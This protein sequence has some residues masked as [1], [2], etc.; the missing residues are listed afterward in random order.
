MTTV[1]R[2]AHQLRDIACI[3]WRPT[4]FTFF[5]CDKHH[6]PRQFGRKEFISDCNAQVT[7][8]RWEK[9]GQELKQ[10]PYKKTTYWPVPQDL[11]SLLCYTTWDYLQGLVL[12][13]VRWILTH[14]SSVEKMPHR[15]VYRPFWR[16]HLLGW[17]SLSSNG[18]PSIKGNMQGFLFGI[19][20]TGKISFHHCLEHFPNV[21]SPVLWSSLLG[22]QLIVQSHLREGSS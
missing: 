22:C 5:G 21:E 16:K 2:V 17:G 15:F 9:S 7:A 10:I 20:H 19:F 6:D 1:W 12:P 11:L 18:S 14:Q 4:Q 8:D 3:A 13:T